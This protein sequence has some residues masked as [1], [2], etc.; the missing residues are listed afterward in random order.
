MLKMCIYFRAPRVSWKV[1]V[2]R[3]RRRRLSIRVPVELIVN[4]YGNLE[5]KL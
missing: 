4:L 5:R 1:S 2:D 3:S